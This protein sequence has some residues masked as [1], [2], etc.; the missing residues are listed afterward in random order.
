MEDDCI[1]A[2]LIEPQLERF[3]EL[4]GLDD[5]PLDAESAHYTTLWEG[6]AAHQRLVLVALAG[7]SGPVYSEEYR[8]RHRLGAVSSVQKSIARLVARELI[9][10]VPGNGYRIADTFLRAWIGQRATP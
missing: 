4:C 8:H 10:H 5:I 3:R 1:H 2:V 9:E 6:L 7:E